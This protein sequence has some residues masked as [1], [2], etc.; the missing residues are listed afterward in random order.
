MNNMIYIS[1]II[2]CIACYY[3]TIGMHNRA[4]LPLYHIK[5][6]MNHGSKIKLVLNEEQYTNFRTWLNK[7]TDLYEARQGDEYYLAINRLYLNA[8]EVKKR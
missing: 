2:V 7:D 6:T 4:T 3:I 1:I 8:V 5:V